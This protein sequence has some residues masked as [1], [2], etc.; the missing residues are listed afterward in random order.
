MST[1]FNSGKKLKTS[2]TAVSSSTITDAL[3]TTVTNSDVKY[4]NIT[5]DKMS[6]VL[7][8]EPYILF[9]D[10]TIQSTGYTDAKDSM[11][12][13]IYDNTIG[14]E[15]ISDTTTFNQPVNFTSTISMPTASLSISNVSGLASQ[16][17]THTSNITT[18]TNNITSNTNSINVITSKLNIDESDIQDLKAM[19]ITFNTWKAS[20]IIIVND[21]QSTQA[22]ILDRLDTDESDITNLQG[23]IGTLSN[24]ITSN[25][26]AIT[27]LQNNKA[28][29]TTVTNLSNK[30]VDI[31]YANGTTVINNNTQL[32][33]AHISNL[34]VDSSLSINGS[35]IISNINYEIT[36]QQF[37]Y[38][39]SI[40][41]DL[42]TSLNNIHADITENTSDILTNTN[43]ILT[44]TNNISTNTNNIATI[45]SNINT[46]NSNIT[47]LTSTVS[48]NSSNITSLQ[49]NTTAQ[50]GRESRTRTRF[51]AIVTHLATHLLNLKFK[52]IFSIII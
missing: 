31:S 32:T 9:P 5:G 39:S 18:N 30:I 10:S 12:Q 13:S 26:T 43:D 21:L 41:E 38:L 29:N 35:C 19:D 16:L 44:N 50:L 3:S 15:N 6:G 4:V 36:D 49:S 25:T 45:N 14:I 33:D 51:L 46:I 2:T 22:S 1:I 17:S 24:S 7:E 27:N 42:A 28:D 11:M 40:Q 47:D 23:S 20:N 34:E 52:L 8:I 37:G 48:T